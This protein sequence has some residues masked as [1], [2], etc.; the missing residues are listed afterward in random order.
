MMPRPGLYAEALPS[1][2]PR[3]V[4]GPLLLFLLAF[5]AIAAFDLDRRLASLWYDGARAGGWLGAGAGDWWAHELLHDAGRWV[6]RGIAALA[7]V[8]WLVSFAWPRA[9]PWRRPAGFVAVSMVLAVGLVGALKA[10]TNVDCPWDLA[11]FGGDRPYVELFSARAAYLPRAQCFPGAHASSG[12]ALFCFY[13][14]WR[15]RAPAKARAALCAALALGTA[16][17]IGQEARGAHFVSHDLASAAIVWFVQ[18]A[19]YLRYR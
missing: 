5:A 16:F 10:T 3:H 8:T 9:R 1:F 19:L 18:L 11:G 2:W 13:F 7:A 14:L 6:V 17:A 15:D 4:I 12:F